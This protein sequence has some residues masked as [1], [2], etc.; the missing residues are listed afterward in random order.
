M[1]AMIAETERSFRPSV[2]N[3]VPLVERADARRK[4]SGAFQKLVDDA[5]RILLRYALEDACGLFLI[6]RHFAVREQEVML[7][8]FDRRRRALITK[9]RH[10]SSISP[11]LGV[12]SRWVLQRSVFVP[13]EF[14]SDPGA[15]RA[16]AAISASAGFVRDMATAILRHGLS[17]TIGIASL[18]RD[19]LLADPHQ[20]YVER[21]YADARESVVRICKRSAITE[22]EYIETVWTVERQG[23]EPSFACVPTWACIPGSGRGPHTRV[24]QGHRREQRGQA[25]Q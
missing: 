4:S 3:H 8:C 1:R 14:S 9:S 20:A 17:D 13:L 5:A 2:Y 10:R 16:L 19:E 24:L 11:P 21:N 12:P 18:L 15:E 7:E 25:S 6:H 23:S 22:R